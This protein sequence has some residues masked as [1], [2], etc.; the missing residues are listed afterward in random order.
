MFTVKDEPK[1]S[2]HSAD[3]AWIFWPFY[4]FS[5]KVSKVQSLTVKW[6]IP[7]EVKLVKGSDLLYQLHITAPAVRYIYGVGIWRSVTLCSG[8]IKQH[9]H[10]AVFAES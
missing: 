8:A 10:L 1:A 5:E 4:L 6:I 2:C 7:L 3:R 9:N